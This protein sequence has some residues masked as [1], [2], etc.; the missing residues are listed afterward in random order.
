MEK[1]VDAQVEQ[2]VSTVKV[3]D[4]DLLVVQVESPMPH[5]WIERFGGRLQQAITEHLGVKALVVIVNTKVDI[6][7][8]KASQ[9]NDIH[10]RI[11]DLDSKVEDLAF[12][13][14]Q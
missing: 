1:L 10:Q 5:Q 2:T 7:V 13:L 14:G 4:G 9:L 12:D 6:S 8:V 11:D 3:E